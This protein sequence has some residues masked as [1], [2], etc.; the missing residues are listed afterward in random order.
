MSV[1]SLKLSRFNYLRDSL[2]D[3]VVILLSKK[4]T[5]NC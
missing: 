5:S 4:T 1:Y 3:F 2:L